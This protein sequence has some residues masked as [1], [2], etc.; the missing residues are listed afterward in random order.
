M[1]A[2]DSDTPTR[3]GDVV[4]MS[5]LWSD[6]TTRVAREFRDSFPRSPDPT[7]CRSG[8]RIWSGRR[9]VP[10]TM[11]SGRTRPASARSATRRA[12]GISCV[13]RHRPEYPELLRTIPDPP[14]VLWLLASRSPGAAQRL[15]LSSDRERPRRPARRGS[16]VWEV[17]WH[18]PALPWSAGWRVGVDGAVTSW[19]ARRRSHGRGPWLRSLDRVYP[20]T[21]PGAGQANWEAGRYH[22]RTPP[23]V[24]AAVAPLSPEKPDHQRPLLAPWSWSRPQTRAARS[25][26]RGLALEQGRDVLAVPG[27]MPLRQ[28]PRRPRAHKGWRPSGRD[29][30]RIFLTK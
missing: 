3:S 10:A 16:L 9:D 20:P 18:G 25:S 7:W 28:Q 19:R 29:G 14:P 27:G 13:A 2:S 26:P 15:S 1:T 11:R 22:V 23:W 30:W 21:A 6:T 5:V 17:S 4:A 12:L 24:A 8:R